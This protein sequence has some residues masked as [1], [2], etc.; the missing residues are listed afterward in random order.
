MLGFLE[1]SGYVYSYLEELDLSENELEKLPL[2]FD[3][4]HALV[5]LDVSKNKLTALPE[6]FAF[7]KESLQ[8]LNISDNP[9]KSMPSVVW[10]MALLRVLFA[11]N[12]GKVTN[13]SDVK[14]LTELEELSLGANIFDSIPNEL[15]SLHLTYLNLSGVPWFPELA[16]GK[17]LPTFKTFQEM[18]DTH[19]VFG[20]MLT[21]QV[22]QYTV[23]M[24]YIIHVY[25]IHVS[26]FALFYKAL[27][28]VLNCLFLIHLNILCTKTAR[29]YTNR[30]LI[31]K[32]NIILI[33]PD[34][35]IYTRN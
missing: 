12:I 7:L 14:N 34:R 11:S 8:M 33:F 32:I 9:F 2:G 23:K 35:N 22:I 4:S 31:E 18:L 17:S 29:F 10:Q 20:A 25:E 30:Q 21:Q 3:T 15:G 28:S 1:C 16:S 13:W 27:C 6:D 19:T 26:V 5:S 24:R